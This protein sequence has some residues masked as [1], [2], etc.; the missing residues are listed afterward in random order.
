MKEFSDID[1]QLIE[2]LEKR[3]QL[4]LGES[5]AETWSKEYLADLNTGGVVSPETLEAIYR[6]IDSG[7]MTALKTTV[8]AFLGT[9]A[10]FTHQAAISRF[11]HSVKYLPQD[12]IAS[13]FRKVENGEADFGVVPIENSTEGAVNRT[14]DT[15]IN[16]EAT[17]VGEIRLRIHHNFLCNVSRQDVKNIYSHPQA[18]AQCHAWLKAN[19]PNAQ[20]I[21]T[22]STTEGAK[23]AAESDDSAAVAS[24]QAAEDFSLQVLEKNIEDL[25][26]NSTR[27]MI[28][29]NRGTAPTGNDKTSLLLCTK[30]QAGALYNALA[31]FKKHG[32]SLT[33][34]ESRPS[35]RRSWEY[36]FFIDFLGHVDDGENRVMLEELG[37][38]CQFV[39]PLGSYPC[40]ED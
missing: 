14:L 5:K 4:A 19:F 29:S 9:T 12:D 28:I 18:L 11:G 21:E 37:A 39:K 20:L 7:N 23:I 16:T 38:F 3:Q 27:F 1:R 8:V 22:E 17:I 35:K 30:D 40:A 36:F 25:K 24:L 34:I 13:I 2:L 15:L 33:M 32:V 31:P 6:E 26:G 10:S